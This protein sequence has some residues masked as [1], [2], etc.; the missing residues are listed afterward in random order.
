M[1]FLSEKVI[2]HLVLTLVQLSF[3]GSS[4]L[5]KVVLNT[6]INPYVFA[7]YRDAVAVLVLLPMVP[8]MERGKRPRSY[9]AVIIMCVALSLIGVFGLQLLYLIGLSLCSLQLAAALFIAIPAF[10]FVI[11]AIFR[12]DE[13]GLLKAGGVAFCVG[14]AAVMTLFKG[15][16]LISQGDASHL[17]TQ[18]LH[19]IQIPEIQLWE[20]SN[21]TNFDLLQTQLANW[22]LGSLLLVAACICVAASANIQASLLARYPAPVSITTFTHIIGA[23]MLLIVSWFK[24][25]DSSLWTLKKSTEIIAVVYAGVIPSALAITLFAWC[26]QKAGPLIVISYVPVQMILSTILGMIFLKEALRLGS[27]IGALLVSLGLYLVIWGQQR[28]R[29]LKISLTQS[30]NLDSSSDSQAPFLDDDLYNNTGKRSETSLDADSEDSIRVENFTDEDFEWPVIT[31][32]LEALGKLDF[33]KVFFVLSYVAPYRLEDVLSIDDIHELQ[34]LPMANVESKLGQAVAMKSNST[35]H[36]DRKGPF[37]EHTKTHLQRVLGDEHV[38]QVH[39]A[40]E[41]NIEGK[42]KPSSEEQQ[43]YHKLAKGG[44]LVGLRRYQFFVFKDGG[45]EVKRQNSGSS[46][47]RCYFVCTYSCAEADR[48]SPYILFNKPI[49]EA[50]R[51]FMH[52][53]TVASLPKYMAR[54]SLILSKTIKFE[55]DISD[56]DVKRVKDIPCLDENQNEVHVNGGPLIHTDGTGFISE[57]LALQCPRNTYKPKL[58][59]NEHSE[60]TWDCLEMDDEYQVM[61]ESI[62]TVTNNQA[63]P[64]LLQCRLFYN[65]SAIKGTFLVNKQVF[66]VV[67]L[68]ESSHQLASKQVAFEDNLCTRIND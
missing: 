9:P 67:T 55:G 50:R 18:D 13:N 22:R 54:F 66:I 35:F 29:V 12:T 4:V 33:P 58:L 49:H 38:L 41:P 23:I 30:N 36:F 47:V 61:E 21:F 19:A 68:L 65:G 20:N 26:V 62:G 59:K 17:I 11:A 42:S 3:A 14:G 45:K 5:I 44:I 56:V 1:K 2:I 64:L 25:E 40:E 8:V 46:S 6:G 7:V 31:E 34:G 51:L 27:L 53:H 57:D 37:L 28:D 10:T 43:R 24:L 39:F 60:R 32:H 16:A 63:Y 48:N 52:V 15:P